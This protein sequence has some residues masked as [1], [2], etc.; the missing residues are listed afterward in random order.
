MVNNS[1]RHPWVV[2]ACNLL[3]IMGIYTIMRLFFYAVNRSMFPDVSGARL[4]EMVV[5][6]WRFDLTALLY[7]NS[8]YLLLML[9][10]LPWSWRTN[11]NFQRVALWLYWI[12]NSLGIVANAVDTVYVRFT[13][14]RTT[15]SVF[16]EFENDHNLGKIIAESLVQYW[17]VTLFASVLII[18]LVVLT[19]RLSQTQAPYTSKPWLYYPLETVLFCFSIYFTVIGIR[20]GFGSW[21][22]PITMSNALQYTNRPSEAAIVLNTPFVLMRS[23]EGNGYKNPNYFAADELE[24]IYSPLHGCDD[25]VMARPM[26][27][28]V[29]IMESFAKEHIGFYNEDLDEGTYRGFT[30]FLDSL[31]S[32][33]VTYTHS[34]ATGRKS[35]DA[36]PSILSSLP[37][38]GSPY[39][40]TPY[41]VNEVMSIASCLRA[42]GYATAFFHGAPNGSMGFQAYA[43]SCGFA[44]YEGMDEYNRSCERLHLE[45]D[46]F[47]GT[48]AIWDE[49]FLQFYA[50]K[51]GEMKQPFMSA[52]FTAS[53]HHPFVIPEQYKDSFP[54]GSLLIHKCI[55]Y[56]D[57]AL[58]KFF[59]FAKKQDWYKNTIFAITADHT[60]QTEQPVYQTDLGRFCVPIIFFDPSGSLP[61][62][63]SE[64]IAQQIDIMPTILSALNYDKPYL[65]FG[66]DLLNEPDTSKLFAVNY[67]N[68]IYQYI[69]NGLVLQFDGA[70]TIGLYQLSDLLMQNNIVGQS[71]F[72]TDME[73]ELKAVIQQYMSRMNENRLTVGEQV[74]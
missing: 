54:E 3:L 28:V 56:T 69:K 12:P 19:R 37:R 25:T 13:H 21:T 61:T 38:F 60:N 70:K 17:Y 4:W 27:V 2:A 33:S 18:L 41:Y 31:L 64:K 55:R 62:G 22:R 16:T 10:P 34:F 42:E 35:I 8:L 50:T 52:V 32:H 23:S 9:V 74:N 67:S 43:R 30:P 39:I 26:N 15:L 51:M 45:P 40:L 7:L 68:G 29:F 66:C 47:D 48:W 5:G 11:K 71:D 20:G 59:D 1:R 14:Q 24:T 44:Q 72:Q 63:I 49:P 36:M 57:N 53:S 58:R 46:A 65:G 73:R 6:G